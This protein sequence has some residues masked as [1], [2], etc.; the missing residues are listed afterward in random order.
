M[1]QHCARMQVG[2]GGKICIGVDRLGSPTHALCVRLTHHCIPLERTRGHMWDVG[3][4]SFA[5]LHLVVRHVFADALGRLLLRLQAHLWLLL[6]LLRDE[7]LGTH[8][9]HLR[10]DPHLEQRQDEAP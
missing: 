7:A 6:L 1:Q 3:H 9:N 2:K 10:L 5:I 4:S 8:T